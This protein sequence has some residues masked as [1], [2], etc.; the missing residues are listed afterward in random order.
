VKT[1]PRYTPLKDLVFRILVTLADGDRDGGSL[2]RALAEPGDQA[3]I[4]PGHLYRTLD[5]MLDDGLIQERSRPASR[6]PARTTRGASPS[7][8]FALTPLGR[9]W[10]RAETKRLEDLV[11]KSRAGRLLKDPR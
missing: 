11:A 10:A 7:R 3:R 1:E 2:A 4:L 8:F 6:P 5:R 9:D